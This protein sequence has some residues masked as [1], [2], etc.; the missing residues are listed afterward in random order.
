M[1]CA[2]R[3]VRVGLLASPPWLAAAAV[4]DAIVHRIPGCVVVRDV[5]VG[6]DLWVLALSG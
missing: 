1:A 2:W 6:V 5:L 3:S 4:L